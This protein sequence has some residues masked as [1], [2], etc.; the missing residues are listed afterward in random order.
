M[1]GEAHSPPWLQGGFL[2]PWD[3]GVC[4]ASGTGASQSGT[5]KPMHR[6]HVTTATLNQL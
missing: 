3:L 6:G 4:V 2:V 5:P 1:A